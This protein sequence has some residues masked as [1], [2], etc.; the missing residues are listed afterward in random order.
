LY[1]YR[2]VCTGINI[3]HCG[4]RFYPG[5]KDFTPIYRSLYQYK[6]FSTSIFAF[7]SG[8]F[9]TILSH[10]NSLTFHLFLLFSHFSPFQNYQAGV[11]P[12]PPPKNYSHFSLPVCPT[13]HPGIPQNPSSILEERFLRTRYIM[14]GDKRIMLSEWPWHSIPNPRRC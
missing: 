7:L 9:K 5:T 10:G 6:V 1:R 11:H 13:G 3:L 8:K 12:L 2:R 4:K 14:T